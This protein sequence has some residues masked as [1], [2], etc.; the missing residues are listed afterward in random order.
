MSWLSNALFA[1]TGILESGGALLSVASVPDHSILYRSGTTIAG[2]VGVGVGSS[3]IWNGTA[4]VDSVRAWACGGTCTRGLALVNTTAAAAGAQQV[5]PSL[6]LGGQ[7]WK[8]DAV[9]ASQA[10]AWRVQ[11]VPVQGAAAPSSYIDFQASIAGG[12]YASQMTVSSIGQVAASVFS[13]TNYL[14]SSGGTILVWLSNQLTGLGVTHNL[15]ATANYP[16]ALVLQGRTAAAGAVGCASVWDVN[17]ASI[18]GDAILHSFGWTDNAN[19]FHHA[20]DIKPLAMRFVGSFTVVGQP[21]GQEGDL[22]YCT[23]GDTGSKCLAFHD[24]VS[25][26][27]IALGATIA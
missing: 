19:V 1:I 7:G 13:S 17:A 2:A 15:I 24:G 9:A 12:A 26:K 23:D 4:F 3:L 10:I 22:G 14:A 27:R 25:W 6:E 21:T 18:D 20:V 16:L 8:T 5:S 11:A